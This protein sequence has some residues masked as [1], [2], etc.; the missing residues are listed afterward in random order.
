MKIKSVYISGPYSAGTTA[1]E[2]HNI[3]IAAKAAFRYYKKGYAV[4]CPHLQTSYIDRNFNCGE[5]EYEDWLAVD[6]YWLSKCDVIVF[7][8]GWEKSR[9]ARIERMAARG[10]GKKIVYLQGRKGDSCG[11]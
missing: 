5:V 4:F 9:G 10:L 6:I 3:R 2:D 11:E 7:L 8:P 1:L